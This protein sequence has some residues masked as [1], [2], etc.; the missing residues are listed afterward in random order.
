MV[1]VG[2]KTYQRQLK[3]KDAYLTCQV[4]RITVAIPDLSII[5]VGDVEFRNPVFS[6]C[7]S[8]TPYN[9]CSNQSWRTDINLKPLVFCER[10][11]NTDNNNIIKNKTKHSTKKKRQ[12][13]PP[14]NRGKRQSV[15]KNT[16]KRNLS[17]KLER[18]ASKRFLQKKK[19]N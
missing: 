2:Q 9:N 4:Q 11:D 19:K 6:T 12:S 10:K 7:I 3:S 13:T 14:P 18:N 16:G 5:A 17:R 15:P 8:S 1:L